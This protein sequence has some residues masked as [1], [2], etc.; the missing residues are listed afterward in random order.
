[1]LPGA[2]GLL[3]PNPGWEAGPV[4]RLPGISGRLGA[5]GAI[6]LKGPWG[7]DGT[8]NEGPLGKAEPVPVEPG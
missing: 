5:I 4:G 6:V 2:P 8:P 3:D 7:P 1:M